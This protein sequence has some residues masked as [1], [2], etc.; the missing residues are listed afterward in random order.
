MILGQSAGTE[1]SSLMSWYTPPHNEV[2]VVGG[3]GGGVG[4]TGFTTSV[5]LSVRPSVRPASRVRSVAP[6]VL[7][8]S[9]SYSSI[10]SSNFRRCVACKV[11][12]KI[13]RF[14]FLA[15]F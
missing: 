6:S 10:L 5:R 9:I 13:S 12:C 11:F 14:V 7:V 4:D 3:G 8:G 1:T 15:I 2:V